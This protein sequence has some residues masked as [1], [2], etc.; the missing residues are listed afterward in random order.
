LRKWNFREIDK[1]KERERERQ[2]QKDRKRDRDTIKY[3][4]MIRN[5]LEKNITRSPDNRNARDDDQKD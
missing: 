4:Q 1:E 5:C 2:R 3:Y